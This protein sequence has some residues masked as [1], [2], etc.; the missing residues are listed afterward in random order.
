[1]GS[2]DLNF[3]KP[4]EIPTEKGLLEKGYK[5]VYSYHENDPEQLKLGND[6]A[7]TLRA[8]GDDI[9]VIDPDDPKFKADHV[10]IVMSKRKEEKS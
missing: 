4:Q 10:K 6:K 9:V 1:M 2:P 7:R 3:N 8:F 5:E